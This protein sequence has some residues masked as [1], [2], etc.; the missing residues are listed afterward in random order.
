MNKITTIKAMPLREVFKHALREMKQINK[1]HEKAQRDLQALKGKE[2]PQKQ[3]TRP[4]LKERAQYL[5]DNLN[6]NLANKYSQTSK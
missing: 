3:N 4:S 2:I 1:D 6:R 5:A